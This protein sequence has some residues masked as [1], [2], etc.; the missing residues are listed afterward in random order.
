M[1][2]GCRQGGFR[3]KIPK[4]RSNRSWSHAKR[5]KGSQRMIAFI[6]MWGTSAIPY[7]E[8]CRNIK[9]RKRKVIAVL[10]RRLAARCFRVKPISVNDSFLS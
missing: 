5:K 6:R 1:V 4:A 3:E 7:E 8:K 10:M 2:A 9:Y